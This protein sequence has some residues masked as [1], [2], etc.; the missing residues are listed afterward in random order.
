MVRKLDSDT[1]SQQIDLHLPVATV[2][3]YVSVIFRGLGISDR[4]HAAGVTVQHG[5][6]DA[7]DST[8]PRQEERA[9]RK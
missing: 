7:E 9:W 2:R 6:L 4:T 5:L 8:A 3:N 1:G